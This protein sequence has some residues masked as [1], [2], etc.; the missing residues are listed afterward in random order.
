MG[1]PG[2]R[3]VRQAKQSPNDSAA[4]AN[5]TCKACGHLWYV[6]SEKTGCMYRKR[7]ETFL[8][9]NGGE[10]GCKNRRA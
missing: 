1:I 9:T 5:G 2:P 4:E 10:C 6:H 8:R 7:G 3:K